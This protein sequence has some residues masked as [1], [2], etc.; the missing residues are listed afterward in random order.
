MDAGTETWLPG[1]YDLDLR[2]NLDLETLYLQVLLNEPEQEHSFLLSS[3]F[4]QRVT[5]VNLFT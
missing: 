1:A 2:L 5:S 3:P 4:K